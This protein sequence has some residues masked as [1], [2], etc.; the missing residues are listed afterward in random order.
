MPR[1]VPRPAPPGR[2][3]RPSPPG[4][5]G[6]APPDEDLLRRAGLRLAAG[7]ARATE[8]MPYL[9]DALYAV[10]A[11]PSTQVPTLAIDTRWR[12][13]Y[14]PGFIATLTVEQVAGAWL[15]EVGHPLRRHAERFRDLA[16]PA[17][18]AGLWNRAADCAVNADLRAA[19]VQLPPVG[20]WFPEQV[21]GAEEGSTAEQL[22]RLLLQGPAGQR[23]AGPGPGLLLLPDTLR[24]D[25]ALPADVLCL[26]REPLLDASTTVTLHRRPRP[27]RD[28][29]RDGDGGDHGDDGEP[30]TGEDGTPA[31]GALRVRGPRQGSFTLGTRLPPG[32]YDVVVARGEERARAG[33]TITTPTLRLRPDHLVRGHGS[34]ARVVLVG[35]GTRFDATSRVEV[36]DAAGRPLDVVAGVEHVSATHLAVDLAEVP[37]GSHRVRATTGPEVVQAVLP[38]GRPFLT[39]H[40]ATLPAGHRTP[41]TLAVTTD[42]LV[43]D[44]TSTLA[45]LDPAREPAEVVAATGPL[46]VR[47]PSVAHV[48]LLRPLDVGRYAVVLTT[49]DEQALATL[50]VGGRA[51]PAASSP[52]PG[53]DAAD[54]DADPADVPPAAAGEDAPGP[55]D[56]DDDGDDGNDGD[57]CG[58][59]A[60]GPRR[61]WEQDESGTDAEG[62]DDGSVD[63]GRAELIRQQTAR[64]VLEHA[65]S[66][67]SVPAG[68]QRWATLVLE[69]EV[70]WRRELDSVTRRVSANVAGVRDYSYARPS[71]RAASFPG[72]VMPAMRQP[73]PPRVAAV[74]DTSGSISD[75]MLSRVHAE[76][77]VVVRRCRGEGVMVIACD[78]AASAPR[79]VRSMSE[80]R[81]VGG[82]GT[83][84]RE[85]LRAAARARPR[86]DL[87][88]TM[89]D[90]DTPWPAAPPPENPDAR[91]VVLLL[92]GEREG[93]PAWMHTIVVPAG[94]GRDP[95]RG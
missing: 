34:P 71:R 72:V 15:H 39:L 47:S 9:A 64:A 45:V 17:A 62:R 4:R 94:T 2:A 81:M 27:A 70:D 87:V 53:A 73:R 52:G 76:T 80:V 14:H 93:V 91:Y 38:V 8:L 21:P 68:W 55:G 75:A 82:G 69:P 89:T 3:P 5:A 59:G 88:I 29:G 18:R 65:R 63:A 30:V 56:G 19:G 67:G 12:M 26:T 33:F 49:G 32:R 84:M 11:V 31:L 28:G 23:P 77:A 1:P 20:A 79:T 86:F 95:R 36:L 16:E 43:V 22:Y 60:G 6:D 25:D 58:S 90:G 50:T 37:E 57:D 42:D 74:V 54:E 85:G 66:R 7:R 40:P 83:D 46:E 51:A 41:L 61:A 92:D 13:T 78:A 44:A 10:K 35:D 24:H 48:P